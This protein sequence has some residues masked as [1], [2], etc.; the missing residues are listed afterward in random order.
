MV[1][2]SSTSLDPTPL[3]VHKIVPGSGGRRQP[4]HHRADQQ[5]Q[6]R[7]VEATADYFAMYSSNPVSG[8]AGNRRVNTISAYQGNAYRSTPVAT[9]TQFGTSFKLMGAYD[10]ASGTH[11]AHVL[12][13]DLQAKVLAAIPTGTTPR[14]D[15]QIRD[16]SY[17]GIQGGYGITVDVQDSENKVFISAESSADSQFVIAMIEPN[18]DIW[19]VNRVQ[20]SESFLL[21]STGITNVQG[22][23][24][25]GDKFYF[26]TSGQ[27]GAGV[28]RD[29]RDDSEPGNVPKLARLRLPCVLCGEQHVLCDH[30]RCWRQLLLVESA[31]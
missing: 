15:E 21:V 24:R 10:N 28:R 19:A 3:S 30:G 13:S 25:D 17:A 8:S 22:V 12:Y 20:P 18:G 23:A 14:T 6:L 29:C 9:A 27:R 1:A 31:T 5:R 2:S 7:N 11:P 16:V 4:G 26:C